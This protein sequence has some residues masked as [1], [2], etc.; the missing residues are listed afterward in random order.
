[1]CGIQ[2]VA[3]R[4]DITPRAIRFYEDKG[5]I[6]PNRE[7]GVRVFRDVDRARLDRI[8]M[9][10]RLG[11]TLDDIKMVLDVMD[12]AITDRR[13]LEMRKQNFERAIRSLKRRHKDVEIITAQM[14]DLC[15]QIDV[16]LKE[17]EGD[18]GGFYLAGAYQAAFGDFAEE[19]LIET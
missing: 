18:T 19:D 10:K 2:E 17:T 8:L 15:R 9:A 16:R 13:E 1:M 6:A 14:S 12:G 3:D 4:F 5:L 11:F 7:S